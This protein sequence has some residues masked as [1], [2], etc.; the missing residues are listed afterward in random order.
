[1]SVRFASVANILRV[2]LN[3]GVCHR[4]GTLDLRKY[5]TV[6]LGSVSSGKVSTLHEM[7]SAAEGGV[8]NGPEPRAPGSQFSPR[9][10]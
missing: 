2:R 10:H 3:G 6:L 7:W 8:G 1:M 4:T 9:D 5:G